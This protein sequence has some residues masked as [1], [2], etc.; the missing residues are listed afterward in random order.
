MATSLREGKLWN[1]TS[2]TQLKN[3][4]CVSS[5]RWWR[6]SVNTY[7]IKLTHTFMEMHE[8]SCL[9]KS[10]HANS[11]SHVFCWLIQSCKEN[12][13][14]KYVLYMWFL[15]ELEIMQR[16]KTPQ[17]MS[18]I[19]RK[20]IWW[21]GSSNAGA[22]RECRVPLHCDHFQIHSGPDIILRTGAVVNQWR[23]HET[24]A[25]RQNDLQS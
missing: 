1:P 20:K 14:Y 8:K 17:R 18:W 4:P 21:W 25:C 10:K 13:A 16:V 24:S 6:G 11:Q 5:C 19:W 22:L 7:L 12:T 2:F 3:W 9:L 23:C 15:N